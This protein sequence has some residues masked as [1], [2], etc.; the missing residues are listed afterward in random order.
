MAL[1]ASFSTPLFLLPVEKVMPF[2]YF[3]EELAK[4]VI[5]GVII[6]A[7]NRTRRIF[8]VWVILAGMLF[9]I[10]ESIFY[11]VNIFANGNLLLFPQR[12]F[13]TGTLHIFTFLLLYFLG[14]KN[15]YLLSVGYFI[16]VTTHWFFNIAVKNI[17]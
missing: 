1:L 4:L 2:P 9:T 8:V 11:L 5:V 12:I 15:L 6:K 17:Y 16:A 13:L 3:I 14:R 10:S 7:E